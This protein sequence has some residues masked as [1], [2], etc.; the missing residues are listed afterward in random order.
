MLVSTVLTV[1]PK[2]L[3]NQGSVCGSWMAKYGDGSENTMQIAAQMVSHFSVG[4]VWCV[5]WYLPH[6]QKQ[7]FIIKGSLNAVR[8]QNEIGWEGS[9]GNPISTESGNTILHDDNTLPHKAR[10]I[11]E[12]LQIWEWRGRNDLPQP[13]CMLYM[14]GW[15]TQ[16]RWLTLWLRTRTLCHS[17]MWAG[18]WS[19]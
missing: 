9:S 16:L 11:I 7:N 6:G 13:N 8:Y 2:N 1:E 3:M 10:I 17:K 14:L 18:W 5:E 12:N 4:A 19:A 15:P